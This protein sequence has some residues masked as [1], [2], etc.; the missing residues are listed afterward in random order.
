MSKENEI[1]IRAL[2]WKG[3]KWVNEKDFI[4]WLIS[5]RDSEKSPAHKEAIQKAMDAIL[6]VEYERKR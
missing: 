3:D 6:T 4:Q 1:H 5:H 2:L